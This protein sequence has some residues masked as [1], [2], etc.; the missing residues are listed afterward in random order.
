MGEG[1]RPVNVVR[2]I[3]RSLGSGRREAV[4]ALIAYGAY[5]VVRGVFGGT[6]AEGRDNAADVIALEERLGI[7]VEADLQRFFDDN[8]LAMPFWNLFYPISQV[9]VLPTTMILVYRYRRAAY[10]F[11]R[12]LAFLSWSA[13][14][15]WYALQPVA[16]PRLAGVAADTVSSQTFV[17]LEHPLIQALYNPVAAMPSLHVG[18]APVV[19]WALWHLTRPWWSRALGLA[20]PF[21]VATSIVVTG[22]HYLLDIAGGL[23]VVLPA[24]G[25]AWWL[26]TPPTRSAALE[27]APLPATPEARR[28]P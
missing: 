22:N 3:A 21:L 24:A 9:I 23:A 1:G 25:I 28:A 11:L 2:R 16:P 18:L 17:D 6:L 8:H 4:I 27:P 15:V 20:Y 12:N 5:N 19:A 26:S 13:A 14:L 7:F 10:P